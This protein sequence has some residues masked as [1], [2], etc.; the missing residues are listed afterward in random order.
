MTEIKWTPAG[1]ED[2]FCYQ[3]AVKGTTNIVRYHDNFGGKY[4]G[5][6]DEILTL[7]ALRARFRSPLT[8][9][10]LW[11]RILNGN[12]PLDAPKKSQ[13]G[14]SSAFQ[15]KGPRSFT[16]IA[17]IRA[18]KLISLWNQFLLQPAEREWPIDWKLR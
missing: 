17:Q 7:L 10:A 12:M 15:R 2:G 1:R 9:K 16:T 13:I 5:G 6:P 14:R 3:V 4:E 18:D 8:A 11:H